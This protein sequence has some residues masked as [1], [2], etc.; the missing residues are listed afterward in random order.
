M[1]SGIL[2]SFVPSVRLRLRNLT[3]RILEARGIPSHGRARDVLEGRYTRRYDFS[4][5]KLP[6][7]RLL[8]I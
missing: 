7:F 6:T 8:M 1:D 5:S 2:G 3:M 4:S